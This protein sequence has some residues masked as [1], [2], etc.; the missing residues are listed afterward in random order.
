M[1]RRFPGRKTDW[2]FLSPFILF[3]GFPL[4]GWLIQPEGGTCGGF[5]PP[6]QA[7][8]S[9]QSAHESRLD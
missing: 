1:D 7:E 5:V 8:Q 4:L 6:L 9:A 3:L 2:V